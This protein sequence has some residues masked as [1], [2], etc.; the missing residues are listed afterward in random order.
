[1]QKSASRKSVKKLKHRY[2]LLG[3]RYSLTFFSLCITGLLLVLCCTVLFERCS[4]SSSRLLNI[5]NIGYP[6]HTDS[7]NNDRIDEERQNLVVVVGGGLAGLSAAIEAAHHGA[8]VV[9]LEKE[10]RVG[11][12]SAKATSGINAWGTRTQ[13]QAGVDDNSALFE[14]DT[15]LSG[16]GGFSDPGLVKV[17]SL[18]SREAIEWLE[19]FGVPLTTLSQ[20]GGHSRKRTHRAPDSPD[21]RPVPIGFTT[22]STLQKHISDTMK[23]QITV[24]PEATV[25]KFVTRE[26]SAKKKQIIG[27]QYANKKSGVIDTINADAVILATGG[28]S[29]DRTARSLLQEYAPHLA[30]YPTTNGP[31]ATGDG[32]KMARD[33]GVALVD[34]DKVQLHPTGLIDPKDPSSRTKYLGPEALR[35]SGGILVNKRG[36]RFINELEL[37]SVVSQAIIAQNDEFPNSGGS[38]FAHCI[39][40]EEAVKLFGVNSLG[41]YWKRLGLFVKVEDVAEL[42]KLIGCPEAALKKTLEH[43]EEISAGNRV[44]PLTG[45]SVFPCKLGPQGPFYVAFVTPSIHYTMGGC[46]ISPSGEIQSAETDGEGIGHRRPILGLFGAGEVTGGVHGK[47]RL[48]GNSLLECV[49]FGRV[50]GKRAAEFETTARVALLAGEENVTVSECV[51]FAE[52]GGVELV[53]TFRSAT[54]SCGGQVFQMMRIEDRLGGKNALIP[55]SSRPHDDG[56]VRFYIPD[57]SPSI[58]WLREVTP[59]QYLSLSAVETPRVLRDSTKEVAVVVLSSTY[60]GV[61]MQLIRMMYSS[62]DTTYIIRMFY[63]SGVDPK[64]SD[65]RWLREMQKW[66]LRVKGCSLTADSSTATWSPTELD[67]EQ[68][69]LESFLAVSSFSNPSKS[70]TSCVVAGSEG[71]SAQVQ[72]FLQPVEN[73]PD[74]GLHCHHQDCSLHYFM[75]S[76]AASKEAEYHKL[77]RNYW[78]LREDVSREEGRY[79]AMQRV[80]L[81][82]HN[83]VWTTS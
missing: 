71:D 72:R 37:R 9:L 51:P 14:H 11:G 36:E 74:Q 2:G 82:Y 5:R 38:K 29:N 81:M 59:G 27:V 22:I 46:L 12:N 64:S 48:G 32:V 13:Q 24:I 30:S 69:S 45:K 10:A 66:C 58:S 1:M 33:L 70:S 42:A 80:L 18:R 40:N 83:S 21:G 44:C 20:L 62:V 56:E 25:Q 76:E 61:I 28:F 39:L 55:F 26:I 47:N 41:F 60:A 35:G 77:I 57:G 4:F 34:M 52:G 73:T 78:K 67:I 50:A 49:V 43:Y 6:L 79:A 31:W 23:D 15:H 7:M 63:R 16:A 68:R 65:I 53:L 17:L 8:K 3:K 19:S 75:E 54:V